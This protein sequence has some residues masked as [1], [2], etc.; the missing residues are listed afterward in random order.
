MTEPRGLIE[1]RCAQSADAGQIAQ[2]YAPIVRST[3]IS[4]ETEPPSP[5]VMAQRIQTTLATHPWLVAICDHAV[6][7]YAYASRHRERA[8]YRWSVDVSVYVLDSM[9]GRGVGRSLY[10]ALL[11]ILRRQGFR[12]A[13]AGIAL[14]NPAS[15]RLHES[16]GFVMLGVYREV[17][18]KHG[19]WHDVGWWRLALA[20]G[21]EPPQE[22]I[23]F[24]AMSER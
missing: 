22:P 3:A 7:G 9:R 18:F 20:T 13:F 5:S 14:P 2:I 11:P 16:L 24:G 6:A 17:G 21:D 23:P 12:S 15:V 4:F 19:R 1:I 10:E 8:A